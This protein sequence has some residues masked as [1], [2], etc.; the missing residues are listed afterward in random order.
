MDTPRNNRRTFV[1]RDTIHHLFILVLAIGSFARAAPPATTRPTY[2]L[3]YGGI[4]RGDSSRKQLALI[5]TGGDFGEGTAHV[6]DVLKSEKIRASFFVTG[7]FLRKVELAPLIKRAIAEGHYVGP[8]SD[9]HP[10]YCSWDDRE[11]SLISRADFAADLQKNIDDLRALG[12]LADRN[13]TVYFIPPYEWFNRD[14]VDWARSMNVVLFNF[15]PGSGSNRDYIPETEKK[16]TPSKKIIADVLAYEK[17]DRH[18]LNG[19]LLLMH[20]GS[21]RKDKTFELLEPLV[22]ELKE[23][24]YG[25]ATIDELLR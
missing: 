18:G 11:K 9:R 7:G 16:F 12:A 13:R 14:Q 3:D 2:T 24:G 8:H 15:T 23:R 6:L 21:E 4:V 22:V 5:F 10:L 20:L 19:F 25:F 1:T 17:K